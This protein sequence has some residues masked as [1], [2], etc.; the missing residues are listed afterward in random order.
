MALVPYNGSIDGEK[1]LKPYKGLLE[2]E[3]PTIGGELTKGISSGVD[4][5]QGSLYGA[6]A[7]AANKV[8]ATGVRDWAEAGMKSNFEES[9]QN[10]PA[11]QSYKDVNSVDDALHYAAGGL[12]QLVPFMG[13][14]IVAGLGSRIAGK[15][16]GLNPALSAE[17]GSLASNTATETGSIYSDILDKTG[18]RDSDKAFG[19]GLAAGALDTLPEAGLW[20]KLDKGAG[21]GGLAKRMAVAGATQ[22][23]K[24]ALTEGGQTVLERAAVADADPNQ[25][26]FTP[27][28]KEEIANAMIIGGLG[29]GVAGSATEV[30]APQQQA[31]NLPPIDSELPPEPIA[32]KP[33]PITPPPAPIADDP[34]LPPDFVGTAEDFSNARSHVEQKVAEAAAVDPNNGVLSRVVN[35]G[36]QN[37]AVANKAAEEATAAV[38][39]QQAQE[40]KKPQASEVDVTPPQRD[41][42]DEDLVGLI[43]TQLAAGNQ[44]WPPQMAK[45]LGVEPSRAFAARALAKQQLEA[46]MNPD[47]FGTITDEG[48]IQQPIEAVAPEPV[49]EAAPVTP[50]VENTSFPSFPAANKALIQQG[51]KGTHAPWA[52]G[53]GGYIIK[54]I[55][56]TTNEKLQTGQQSAA[57][58]EGGS[59]AS[60]QVFTK[61]FQSDTPSA[62]QGQEAKAPAG[63]VQ[64][65]DVVKSDKGYDLYSAD[66]SSRAGEGASP[67]E[68]ILNPEQTKSDVNDQMQNRDRSRAAS[69]QQMKQIANNPDYDRLSEAKDPEH[70]APMAYMNNDAHENIPALGKQDV[71]TFEDGGKTPIRY[72]V[73]DA[74]SLQASHNSDGAVNPE[75]AQDLPD[76]ILRSLNNG[77][78]SGLQQAYRQGT[79]EAYRSSLRANAASLGIDAAAIDAIAN[80]VLVRL[81]S[82]KE[83]TKDI[84][85]RSNAGGGL[86]LSPSE[87]AKTD[88]SML[89]HLDDMTLNDDGEFLPSQNRSLVSRFLK[90]LPRTEGGA[91]VNRNGEPT[92]DLIKRLKNAVLSKAYGDND[93]IEAATESSDFRNLMNALNIAAPKMASLP[94]DEASG[95]RRNIVAAAQLFRKAKNENTTVKSVL[96]QGSLF[97]GAPEPETAA[98]AEFMETHARSPKQLGEALRIM[99]DYIDSAY[100]SRNDI[101]GDTLPETAKA[102]F[103]YANKQLK[104]KYGDKAKL[105]DATIVQEGKVTG[106]A[107]AAHGNSPR[108][109]NESGEAGRDQAEGQQQE[110]LKSQEEFSL[111]SYT[112]EE[113]AAKEADARERADKEALADKDAERKAKADA[114]VGQFVLT[115]SDRISDV[116]AAAGQN[117]LFGAGKRAIRNSDE[118]NLEAAKKLLNE[119]YK[120]TV[121]NKLAE[122]KVRKAMIE[123]AK[124][125]PMSDEAT[126]LALDMLATRLGYDGDMGW[127]ESQKPTEAANQAADGD[128]QPFTHSGLKVYPVRLRGAIV[129]VRWAVQ[130][131]ENAEREKNGERQIGGDE[132]VDTR[133]QAI[134]R[135]EEMVAK[136]ESKTKRNA[137]Q[138]ESDR[139]KEESEKTKKAGVF[140]SSGERVEGFIKSSGQ[141]ALAAGRTRKALESQ[142]RDSSGRVSSRA[143]WV[144][145][146]LA[147][148]GKLTTAEEDKIKPMTRA[149]FNRADNREQDAHEKRIKEAGKKTVYRI[150][151]GDSSWE[152]TKT[153]Y[154]YARY[155]ESLAEDV[156]SSKESSGPSNSEEQKTKELSKDEQKAKDWAMS[157]IDKLKGNDPVLVDGNSKT[158]KLSMDLPAW[159][160]GANVKSLW[161]S[162]N[163]TSGQ[164]E[165]KLSWTLENSDTE[166]K[167]LLIGTSSL[168]GNSRITVQYTELAEARAASEP[169]AKEK[170]IQERLYDVLGKDIYERL[171]RSIKEK[172]YHTLF[173]LY[174]FAERAK[175]AIGETKSKA[176]ESGVYD[177]YNLDR[178]YVSVEGMM[179]LHLS[180]K[181]NMITLDAKLNSPHRTGAALSDVLSAWEKYET[182]KREIEESKVTHKAEWDA[183]E[184]RQAELLKANVGDTVLA[185]RAGTSEFHPAKLIR[186]GAKNWR[187]ERIESGV[188]S[189][190]PIQSLKP[191]DSE[192]TPKSKESNGSD[193]DPAAFIKIAA[194]S[195]DKLRPQDVDRV[196]A[197]A[198]ALG[199]DQLAAV[200]E[201]IAKNN[202][203]LREEIKIFFEEV[204]GFLDGTTDKR[205]KMFVDVGMRRRNASDLRESVAKNFGEDLA[206]L[207]LKGASDRYAFFLPDASNAGKFR[208]TH[209]DKN[210]L[211]GHTTYDTYAK[212]LDE[213]IQDGY[214]TEAPG[215][216]EKLS[217][218]DSFKAGNEWA[219]KLQAVHD[220]K[221]TWADFVAGKDA[222]EKQAEAKDPLGVSEERELSD[223]IAS[224]YRNASNS[225]AIAGT[226]WVMHDDSINS[227]GTIQ[228]VS[229]SRNVIRDIKYDPKS[230]TDHRRAIV[231][232]TVWAQENPD[233]FD[234]PKGELESKPIFEK[235]EAEKKTD[236]KPPAAAPAAKIEDFG[237]K[238]MGAR[239]DY[240][241]KLK[242]AQEID[243]AAAPLSKSWPEPDY[244]KLL[245]AGADPYIAGWVHAARDEV[246]TKP[247]KKWKLSG[248]VKSVEMLRSTAIK[249]MSGEISKDKLLEMMRQPEFANV[250]RVIG[251]R[252]ELYE[253]LGHDRS[254]KGITVTMG[255]YGVF[256]GVQYSPAKIIWTAGI[257]SRPFDKSNADGATRQEAIDNY[258]AKHNDAPKEDTGKATKF[259]MWKER[260]VD[261][262]YI[263]KKIGSNYIKLKSFPDIKS[264]REYRAA[265][266]QELEDMLRKY[267]ETP[268]ERNKE[269]KPRVGA[270][271][272]SGGAVTPE[273]FNDAFGFRGVQFGNYVEG[274]KRQGDLDNAYDALSDLAALMNIPT[275]AIS[276]DKKLGLAFGAR[277]KG[278]MN[279]ASA[280]YEPDNVVINLTKNNGAGS[281]AHEWF[282]AVDNYFAKLDNITG[283]SGAMM[284]DGSI[285]KSIRPEMV[286]AFKELTGAIQRSGMRKRSVELDK[287]RSKPYWALYHE[288]AAR[289]FEAYVIQ[290][291]QEQNASN[292]YLANIVGEDF[293]KAQD[294]LFGHEGEETY[295]YPTAE[296]MKNIG[297]AFDKFIATLK[298]KETGDGNVALFSRGRD[299]DRL[300]GVGH[301]KVAEY[302][303][304]FETGKPVIFSFLHNK[305]SATKIYGKPDKESEFG[306][307]Y[308]PSGRYMVQVSK[309]EKPSYGNFDTGSVSFENPLVIENDG[310]RWKKKLSDAYGGLTGKKL[311]QALIDD[312]YDAVVTVDGVH[313]S[314]ILDLTTFDSKKAKYARA[315]NIDT[316]AF[317]KWFGD[318]KVVDADGK[319]LVVY[320]GTKG[321][322]FS[323]FKPSNAEAY[324]DGIYFASNQEM[325]KGEFGADGRVIEAYVKIDNPSDGFAPDG[326][327][328]MIAWRNFK[329]TNP[330]FFGDAFEA[331]DNYSDFRAATIREAGY[332]GIIAENDEYGLEIVAFRPEQ[333]KSATDNNGAFDSSNPDIRFRRDAGAGMKPVQVRAIVNNIAAKWKNAPQ[334]IIADTVEGLPFKAPSDAAG[335]FHNG[336]VYLVA[337]NLRNRDHAEFVL[338]HEALGHYGL[339]GVLG[340]QIKPAMRT[341][342]QQNRSVRDLADKYLKENDG[343]GIDLAVEEALSDL[344]GAKLQKLKGIDKLIAAIKNAIRAMGFNLQLSDNDVLYVMGK[345]REFVEK[346]TT[347][348]GNQESARF[349]SGFHE[350]APNDISPIG[351][352]SP[353]ARA[354]R[355]L[356]QQKG[357]PDQMLAMLARQKGVKP[358]EIEAT[359]LKEYLELASRPTP[360]G[361]SA[362]Y[363]YYGDP[364]A[365]EIAHDAKDGDEKA[366]KEMAI[367]MAKLI[368]EGST[369]VP[370][371]SR[372][373]KAEMTLKLAMHIADITG[374][375]IANVLT[376][377]K[378]ESLYDIKKSGGKLNS[379]QLGIS[380]SRSGIKNPVLIDNVFATGA[381]MAAIKKAL[382]DAVM[383]AFARD[384]TAMPYKPAIITKQQIVDYLASN[385]V[386][387]QES[388]LGAG[389]EPKLPDGW[390]VKYDRE[391]DAW[392][393]YDQDG[394]E[395]ADGTSREDA[396]EM[397]MDDDVRADNA[398][399]AGETKFGQYVLPGGKNYREL[400]LTLP[401]KTS[402][403]DARADY[404]RWAKSAGLSP[405]ASLSEAKYLTE[406]GKT[407]PAPRTMTAM[408]ADAEKNFK[409]SHYGQPNILAHV[410][411]N[412][413]TDADGKRVLFLEELQSDWAQEGRKKGFGS[414]TVWVVSDRGGFDYATAETEAEAQ[415]IIDEDDKEGKLRLT[416]RK[417]TQWPSV[418]SAPFVT[419]T[420]AWVG[421][422]MKRMIAYAAQNGFDRIAWTTG[423]QQAE[424]YDLSKQVDS[425]EAFK[426]EDGTFD[427]EAWKGGKVIESQNQVPEDKLESLFGKDLAKKII[428][429]EGEYAPL[430]GYRSYAGDDLKVG[431]QGMVSF[432]DN[433]V[434][435]VAKEITKKMGGRVESIALGDDIEDQYRKLLGRDGFHADEIDGMVKRRSKAEM[436]STLDDAERSYVDG[437]DQPGFDITPEMRQTTLKGMPLFS[438]NSLTDAM[439]S[440]GILG[441]IQQNLADRFT[442]VKTFNLWDRT[443]G[444]QF[445]KAWKDAEFKKVFDDGQNYLNDVSRFAMEAADQAPGLLPKVELGSVVNTIANY[446][447]NQRDQKAIAAPVYEGTLSYVRDAVTGQARKADETEAGGIVFSDTELRNLFKLND[448]QISLYRQFRAAVDQS[449]EGVGVSEAARELK[450]YD[451]FQPVLRDA[452]YKPD[453]AMARI[454]NTVEDRAVELERGSKEDKKEAV[455]L[456]KVLAGL[457]D[458]HDKIEKL[459]ANGYAPLMRFGEYAVTVKDKQGEVKYFELFES[460]PD[461]LRRYR[462]MKET[463]PQDNVT[464]GV[465]ND[466]KYKLYKDISPDTLEL[467]AEALGA[468]KTDI[469]QDYLKLAKNN[470]SALKRLIQR[471]GIAG[472]SEDS[473]R[474]LAQFITSNARHSSSNYHMGEMEKHVRDV[475]S[476]D[477]Q[478]EAVRLWEYVKNPTEE[479]AKL[480]GYLFIN[481]I[482][483]SI[484]SAIVNMTQPVTM[485]FP[486]L[487]Q[488]GARKASAALAS[489]GKVG[490]TG[491]TND[492]MLDAAMKRATEEGIVAPHEIHQLYAEAIQGL[493]RNPVMRAALTT[494][495]APFSMAE[496]FNRRV[497]FAAAFNMAQDMTAEQLSKA[498]VQS[499][500]QFAVKAVYE[501]QGIYNRGN[502]PDWARGAIGA[503]LFTFKQFSVSYL[504]FLRRLPPREKIIALGVLV[505][506]SGLQGL[507]GADDAEDVIDTIAQ[508]LGYNFDSKKELRDAI[509]GSFIAVLGED[510]GK[511]VG[512]IAAYGASSYL[513]VD[514]QA[515]MS[516]G[517]LIPG[518]SLMKRS[519]E[520]KG[521]EI[522]EVLGPA[523]GLAQNIMDGATRAMTGDIA[524][525]ALKMA[526]SA[527]QNAVKGATAAATGEYRDEQGRKIT[528]ATKAEGS[529]KGIGFQPARIAQ[530]SRLAQSERQ[531]IALTRGEESAIVDTWAKGIAE[532]DKDM[533]SEA[534]D[535]LRTWNAKNPDTKI[536]ISPNQIK[537][538]VKGLRSDRIQR[539]LK[540][541]PKEMRAGVMQRISGE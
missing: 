227:A 86:R 2:G 282:H 229:A 138:S 115:G 25:R 252:A 230:G 395:M 442:K 316:P 23:G 246:P 489:A 233:K 504:E 289:A 77:R 182:S 189:L 415:K 148:G 156:V 496:A 82:E 520:N 42:T 274:S 36:A 344:A 444:T 495:G 32:P 531:S 210:G 439:Y 149:Q 277:G 256:R 391:E 121:G 479:A 312:G 70:G 412:E 238:L 249:L 69:V 541:A 307:G 112:N 384:T 267:K 53:K 204:A 328:Q 89:E 366:I 435:K 468:D 1:T 497:T 433:I 526:P 453:G 179:L 4:V 161:A 298:T 215:S 164:T 519:Q 265:N 540:T 506:F 418:P 264:A 299:F 64:V 445:H 465:M 191:V 13:Q 357:T 325:P 354:A 501:T 536:K 335:A 79:A 322:D 513:P 160:R 169:E 386:Q 146:K 37:G 130:T 283:F 20:N 192:A 123:L 3:S 208:V 155:I 147:E 126:V 517:N 165:T 388:M 327:E 303:A 533:I 305:E 401:E 114:E 228:L 499:K 170:S 461:M 525:G 257:D 317:K 8:G 390:T 132:I 10:A 488:W 446:N 127:K 310:L 131:I 416:L 346:G 280:H 492:K 72:A 326:I 447:Q 151:N 441:D 367:A 352:Y 163:V 93:L 406:T 262:V 91:L 31:Q 330:E 188:S 43:K 205:I 348:T 509:M 392:I 452:K 241:Q 95:L 378:R 368:P 410:R 539:L 362:V 333:I 399:M 103:D 308:E 498:G 364:L 54:P 119:D 510:A 84:G 97:G 81:Y 438:R 464:F 375:D 218:L 29:G 27:E 382:P 11:V 271:H 62:A 76:G 41:Y 475:S 451:E 466:E 502:R 486:Y 443:V 323:V 46:E 17:A 26:I 30:L 137:E 529:W 477:A 48:T 385:G 141:N 294:A 331:F 51:L 175:R 109:N 195:I 242:E 478:K 52:D 376:G 459:K 440:N 458:K 243:V 263:G 279:P 300:K 374:S 420:D 480:R 232:A 293:W 337:N 212:A 166:Y 421:L 301:A 259:D 314:E 35:M 400:L 74:E 292:D 347:V 58:P 371:P 505:M 296:D 135:A 154:D 199:E 16:L 397:A 363:D 485:T 187:V 268:F 269:N 237:E 490:A 194:D 404:E 336:K 129:T 467:F 222:N 45:D 108:L 413:R 223:Y 49:V 483:G 65:A 216:L 462:A 224:D 309:P 379:D 430:N 342:Y 340:N 253:K 343:A 460:K 134:S 12:G 94:S 454:L 157:L 209:F 225:T 411:F 424:R 518:T 19:Y 313:T 507:P 247:Q 353:L 345:A 319:P 78:T 59:E 523:G 456:R 40:D 511:F 355:N 432:Y 251:G 503:T 184:K 99:G 24:E 18:Q 365:R 500:Y 329:K 320:H 197:D 351:F 423:E 38:A 139:Q 207:Q 57:I 360:D 426:N 476:G 484:A 213:A 528:T 221:I 377:N 387:V 203:K 515:R 248:W 275:R 332:D 211:S 408:N 429:E 534:Q 245:A 67:A 437:T 117:D 202:S 473:T 63:D 514:I 318:S 508:G 482:G 39:E 125:T 422:S 281:L 407:A 532:G 140:G 28:G 90:Q 470:R 359:G 60:T 372:N 186:K 71:V 196:L 527:I 66:S 145:R 394:D 15:K 168:K 111:A 6:G 522:L 425:V 92:D 383:V 449:L 153:E 22:F 434:P 358:A 178:D 167:Q 538:R 427:V 201:Y 369:L 176:R 516:L 68:I 240:A 278:G 419:S 450:S 487:S 455:E 98:L 177:Y 34:V 21:P 380:A 481:F 198:Y 288:M 173:D 181:E 250:A 389:K 5:L 287:R 409:S 414:T 88:A 85:A 226:G 321:K 381:T 373:G 474:T 493:G 158:W 260:G 315:G 162:A 200:T 61:G 524:G 50:E 254:L 231:K 47:M 83:N 102:Y 273:A 56:D 220:G 239:K 234:A 133:E 9:A 236:K 349:M 185:P 272:R 530:E 118:P 217:E 302:G 417:D 55:E 535:R 341:I 219:H 521:K 285:N 172:G 537:Q 463:Y 14:S 356:V 448:R 116:A 324:G 206:G 494:W 339:S 471:K 244:S 393:V 255:E 491:K 405:N 304:E 266:Q 436:K 396:I 276:L 290:K 472:Y 190:E 152:I 120:K 122:G 105:I 361:V 80:P 113:I 402:A 284:T 291:L 469:F 297:P 286:E 457:K 311:S 306:R 403:D 261:T 270:D 180:A 106:R 142:I 110:D 73:V 75:Y 171:P 428:N 295:P 100:H 183:Y 174:D 350:E 104:E 107:Q 334:V 370:V 136:H 512:G 96:D 87:Q 159:L 124:K 101:F 193:F 431:G 128:T 143:E 214:K 258:V 33:A 398:D 235:K 7:A 150:E 44:V 144:D 338:L